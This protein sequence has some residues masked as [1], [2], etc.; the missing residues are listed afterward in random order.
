[1]KEKIQQFLRLL[2]NDKRIFLQTKEIE[3][4]QIYRDSIRGKIYLENLPIN[5]GRWAGNYSFFYIL[6]RILNDYKPKNILDLGLGESSKF[7]STYLDNYLTE[8]KHTIVEQD[9][10]WITSF[11]DKFTLSSRSKIIYCELREKQIKGHNVNY[12]EG[13]TGQIKGN[14]DLYIVDGPFGSDRYSRY[15]IVD[16]VENFSF[17]KEFIIIMDDSERQGEQDTI[18]DILNILRTKGVIFYVGVYT[19]NKQ[20]TI[21][22]SE[23][24]KFATSF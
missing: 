23:K 2:F 22:A 9:Q 17:D 4:A 21:I 11:N 7:I 24:Y 18:N 10:S 16:L 6:N 1:M 12:Y 15:D 5:V 20:N 14:F 19:G 8:S 3:W 13:F